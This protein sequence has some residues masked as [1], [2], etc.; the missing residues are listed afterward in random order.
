MSRTFTMVGALLG[1]FFVPLGSIAGGFYAMIRHGFQ[2]A[3]AHVDRE[4]LD[5]VQS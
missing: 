1:S 5:K 4:I 3:V 2:T